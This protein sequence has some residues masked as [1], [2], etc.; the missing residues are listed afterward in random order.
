MRAVFS[1]IDMERRRR[2]PR[3]AATI[4]EHGGAPMLRLVMGLPVDDSGTTAIDYALIACLISI[5][6]VG[7]C[8]T[9]GQII[10]GNFL[11]P[12]GGTLAL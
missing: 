3:M 11:A 5:G 8:T 12:I 7:A 2:R 4:G 10:F 1:A 9:I 6:I